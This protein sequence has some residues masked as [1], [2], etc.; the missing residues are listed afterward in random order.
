MR[1]KP[2]VLFIDI[3]TK[4][5]L[6]WVWAIWDQNVGLNQ[7]KED[8]SI[9][10]YSA[11]WLNDP[12]NK[13]MYKDVSTAKSID[14]DRAV[15]KEIWKLL[16]AADI[17]VTQ[18]G[19][20]FDQKKI[21]ARFVMQ[22][23]QPPSPFKHIDTKVLA[24]KHFG[25]TSNRLEYMTDKLCKKFKKKRH[26]KFSGFGL[27]KECMKNNPK[28]WDAMRIYNKYDVLSLEELYQKLAPWDSS[29]NFNLYHDDT[30]HICSSCGSDE[31]EK[32]GYS[33]TA[34]GKFQRW[35]CKGCGQWTRSAQNL[36][37]KEKRKSLR[38]PA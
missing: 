21:F 28:A 23:M 16:D 37:T 20:A 5:I 3:E 13:T 38:R 34:G 36:L 12:P 18:N 10:S 1:Q 25:F 15:L 4:P 26:E 31:S 22:G 17:V 2:K 27:W 32:R 8:W 24:K 11:K 6:A 19:K 7:I 35:R 9:L 14:D 30:D 29:L 33:Y